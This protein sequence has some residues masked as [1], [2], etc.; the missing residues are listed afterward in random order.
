MKFSSSPAK[1]YWM[2]RSI[3]KLLKTHSAPPLSSKMRYVTFCTAAA[4]LSFCLPTLLYLLAWLFALLPTCPSA[5]I[6]SSLLWFSSVFNEPKR[7]SVSRYHFCFCF[8]HFLSTTIFFI[9]HSYSKKS[10][11]V[12]FSYEWQ[13]LIE[14]KGALDA[15]NVLTHKRSRKHID[16]ALLS[17]QV[18]SSYKLFRFS[19]YGSRRKWRHVYSQGRTLSLSLYIVF[20]FFPPASPYLSHLDPSLL[21]LPLTC[22]SISLSSCRCSGP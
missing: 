22:P 11:S 2:Q 21:P 5:F 20:L 12:F 16:Y 1:H 19:R 9:C 14:A 15:S 6:L 13:S 17:L 4:R 8:S 18:R 7:I 10:F 3:L